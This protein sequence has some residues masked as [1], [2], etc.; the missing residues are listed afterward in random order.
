[1]LFESYHLAHNHIFDVVLIAR[2][3]QSQGNNV[4]IFDIYHE[5]AEDSLDGVPVMH[6]SSKYKVPDDTWRIR[7]HSM[8]ETLIK[9]KVFWYQQHQYMK[10]V[11]AFIENK[12]DVFY[13]GSY[14]NGMSTVLFRMQKP[15]YW[16]GLRSERFRFSWRKL[17]PSLMSGFHI[18]LER[19]RFLKNPFQRLFVSNQ[20][21]VDE[22]AHLGVPRNRMVIREERVVEASTDANLQLLDKNVSFLIIGQLRKEKNIPTSINAFRVAN[23]DGATLKLVGKSRVGYE[24]I[25]KKAMHGDSCFIRQDA[26]LEYDDF[27]KHI[28]ESHFVLFADE[29]SSCCITNGTMMEALINHR[30]II[31]PD[32]NPYKYYVEKYGVGLLYNPRSIDSYAFAMRKASMLGVEYFQSAINKYLQT[33]QFDVVAK[34]LM[35]DINLNK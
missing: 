20:I 9:G 5:I 12:A 2:M 6:W 33:I 27:N 4:V 10:E 31:C 7:K 19:Q 14:H 16:W 25:I 23:I 18:L 15:C 1:M 32:Y 30:P 24:D 28:M 3:L 13:C 21:I 22:H 26:F 11:L 8:W 34:Q 35:R 17:I 29:E